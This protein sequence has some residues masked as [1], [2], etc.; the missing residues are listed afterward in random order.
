MKV[1]QSLSILKYQ[2]YY[3]YSMKRPEDYI[4]VVKEVPEGCR[5][6]VRNG[7]PGI[8]VEEKQHTPFIGHTNIPAPVSVQYIYRSNTDMVSLI[9]LTDRPYQTTPWE[10]YSYDVLFEDIERFPTRIAAEQRIS[11]LLIK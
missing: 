6:C 7:L 1:R 2:P 4:E 11:E 8:S 9:R 3:T 5:L 10:I